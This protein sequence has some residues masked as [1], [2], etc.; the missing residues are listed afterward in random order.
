MSSFLAEDSNGSPA[1]KRRPYSERKERFVELWVFLFLIV[2]SLV[3]S[4]FAV[5]QGRLSFPLIAIATIFRDLSLL[6]LIL[7]FIW[8]NRE[9]ITS[10]G[11]TA[12]SFWKEISIGIVLFVP[13]FLT[14]LIL[15]SALHKAG[16]SAPATPLPALV[17]EKGITEFILALFLVVVVA[18]VEETIFRGYLMLRIKEITSSPAAAVLLSAVIFSIGHGYE[19]TAS[20][21]T[22]GVMGAFLA[23]IYQWRKSLTA[24]IVM[25]F[26]QDFI[27]IVLVPFLKRG[28]FIH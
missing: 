5:R 6:S 23:L 2:P 27:G 3:L 26:L 10:I 22:V 4:F 15:E 28:H 11:W 18:V 8:R 16:L 7:F 21:V 24:P 1:G 9:P 12:M 19:G 14:A 13:L 20:V 25:H 17:G